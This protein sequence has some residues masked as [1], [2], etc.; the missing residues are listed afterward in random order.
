MG[1][2]ALSALLGRFGHAVAFRRETLIARP[3]R[4]ARRR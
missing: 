1:R 4:E 2:R 3:A